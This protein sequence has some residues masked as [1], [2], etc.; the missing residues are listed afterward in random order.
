ELGQGAYGT[1]YAGR[2]KG[3]RVAI[4]KMTLPLE[5]ITSGR[6]WRE[7]QLHMQ[8]SY[9]HV[10]RVYG[11]AVKPH[12]GRTDVQHCYVV[13]ERL[14]TNLSNA[15]HDPFRPGN[16]AHTVSTA[17]RPLPQRLR[18]LL[19][20]ARGVRFLHAKGIVHADLKPGNV[21]LDHDGHAQLADFGLAVQRRHEASRTRTSHMGMRGTR[22]YMDPVLLSE[23]SSVKSSSDMYSWGVMA[24]EVLTLHKPDEGV[25]SGGGD[26]RAGAGSGGAAAGGVGIVLIPS[27][28]GLTFG[29]ER[30]EEV[31]ARAAPGVPL[32]L[33]DLIQRCWSEEQGA[34]PT[35]KDAVAVLEP[36]VEG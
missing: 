20:I 3:E 5:L 22:A 13:M 25:S 7:V 12:K 36:I 9:K 8:A 11:A 34:R 15:L 10:V 14:V 32:P 26:A 4:K 16:P 29:G 31:L 17:V 18:L 27:F 33:R 6:F 1:V 30:P 24:W 35:A 23:S 21:M 2:W 19:E 28:S